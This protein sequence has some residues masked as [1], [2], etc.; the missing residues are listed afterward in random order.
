[1]RVQAWFRRLRLHQQSFRIGQ[2]QMSALETSRMSGMQGTPG[3]GG[4]SGCFTNHSA[5]VATVSCLPIRCSWH[6][7][8]V[9]VQPMRPSRFGI[10][11]YGKVTH[12]RNTRRKKPDDAR[13]AA[14]PGLGCT[15][16]G[17]TMGL[18]HGRHAAFANTATN[19]RGHGRRSNSGACLTSRIPLFQTTDMK[20]QP[21]G[22]SVSCTTGSGTT[23][24]Q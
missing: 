19:S 9:S 18:V 4:R 7:R 16:A 5:S 1:M 6:S 15:E 11:V 17:G 23:K 8:E 24:L 21:S 2:C 10:E 14:V 3:G 20:P 22:N 12:F 13:K